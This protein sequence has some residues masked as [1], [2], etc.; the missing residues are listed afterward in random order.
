VSRICDVTAIN[1]LNE[2]HLEEM[3][4]HLSF[5]YCSGRFSVSIEEIVL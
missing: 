3:G 2:S 4:K 5:N 1:P